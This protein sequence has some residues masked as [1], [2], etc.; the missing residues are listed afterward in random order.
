MADAKPMS[1][2]WLIS[3]DSATIEVGTYT[4]LP[5]SPFQSPEVAA[6]APT[7]HISSL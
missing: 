2:I 1:K 4:P 3:N 6:L 5:A 7:N